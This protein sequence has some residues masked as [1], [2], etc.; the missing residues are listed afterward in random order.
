M[1][2]NVLGTQLEA[3]CL[4][5]VT[6]FYRDGKCNTGRGDSGLHT[7]CVELTEEFLQYARSLGNDLITPMPQYDFPGLKP[8]NHWCVCVR[9]VVDALK[10]KV[11]FK[12]RLNSTHISVKEFIDMDDLMA[13]KSG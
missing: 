6:G 5:P 12:I 9:T 8:G 13:R 11:P 3:C 10:A 7:V 1:A 2:S 4:D